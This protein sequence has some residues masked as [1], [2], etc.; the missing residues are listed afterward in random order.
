MVTTLRPATT[1][2]ESTSRQAGDDPLHIPTQNPIKMWIMNK[3]GETRYIPIH[4][5]GCKNSERIL[6]MKESLNRDSHASSSHESYIEPLRNLVSDKHSFH[7][8]FPKDRNFEI[9]QRTKITRAPCRRRTG[10]VVPRTESFG[11]LITA[12]HEDLSEGCESR[13]NHRYAIVVQDVTTHWVQSYHC[14]T[15]ASQETERSLQKFLQP[16]RKPKVIYTDNFLEFGKAC[17]DLSNH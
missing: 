12:D 2:S 9:C 1:R 16:T 11:D 13:N 3:H 15:L 6:W 8:H 10:E 17:E 7:S 14:K 5:N 4:R